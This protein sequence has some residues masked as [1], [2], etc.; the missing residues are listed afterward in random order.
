MRGLRT[1]IVMVA[2]LLL[3]GACATPR[4]NVPFDRAGSGVT[5]I[6]IVT[7]VTPAQPSI[8]LASTAGQSF[9]LIGA[10]VDAGMQSNRESQYRRVAQE[11]NFHPPSLFMARLAGDLAAAGYTVSNIDVKR[12]KREFMTDYAKNAPAPVDAYLD[13][14]MTHYGYA[15]AGIGSSTPYRP[16]VGLRVRLVSART[17]TVLMQD[18]VVYNPIQYGGRSTEEPNYITIAPDPALFFDDFDALLTRRTESFAA[19]QRATEQTAQTVA[20]LMRQ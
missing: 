13:V 20:G 3:L 19:L 8:V 10:L 16:T 15:A 18:D 6:G 14:L 4:T 1:A 5:T 12:E 9:G 11:A 7:P 17:G 2:S